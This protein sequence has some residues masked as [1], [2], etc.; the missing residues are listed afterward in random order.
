MLLRLVSC[1]SLV[2]VLLGCSIAGSE[3]P[4]QLDE[5]SR[6]E[7]VL[8]SLPRGI[9][10]VRLAVHEQ[11]AR[12]FMRIDDPEFIADPGHRYLLQHKPRP[13]FADIL[14][15]KVNRKTFLTS[16][17]STSI[18]KTRDIILN[19]VK[20]AR[21]G[22]SPVPE[23]DIEARS[24]L[25][26]AELTIDPTI[27]AEMA[28]AVATLNERVVSFAQSRAQSCGMA[29]I[30]PGSPE[31]FVCQEYERLARHSRKGL[32]LIN[33]WVE[34]PTPPLTLSKPADCT[35]GVCYRVASPYRISYSFVG[36]S[37]VQKL[38]ELPNENP[39][40]EI[41]LRRA[42]LV[43]KVKRITFD[44]GNLAE[45]HVDK[46][47]ELL[48]LSKLPLEITKAV[49]EAPAEALRLR[50]AMTNEQKNLAASELALIEQRR[51]LRDVRIRDGQLEANIEVPSAP[52][53]T[54]GNPGWATNGFL[55]VKPR[56]PAQ[57]S[58]PPAQ[59]QGGGGQQRPAAAT[60][61]ASERTPLLNRKQ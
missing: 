27:K 51:Q 49:L 39:P 53:E 40:I 2:A 60:P 23:S 45:V 26:L 3:L 52:G 28:L 36:G 37:I 59:Q 15:I 57:V 5:R 13:N 44:D 30:E 34:R 11:S 56:Q 1:L 46:P 33:I 25:T 4:G 20:A 24:I 7:G 55:P 32:K 8:Y 9:V 42:F 21:G 14:T 31:E 18:D 10:T 58:Q 50:I 29:A 22:T 54:K 47:S 17:D 41:D 48:E 16:V 12:F 19:V 35:I 38:I 61:E 43:K 6:A